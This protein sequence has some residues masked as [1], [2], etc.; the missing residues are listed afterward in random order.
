MT[1]TPDPS[2]PDIKIIVSD[3]ENISAVHMH[4]SSTVTGMT[5]PGAIHGPAGKTDLS[6]SLK[7][8]YDAC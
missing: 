7:P 6:S 8:N 2:T 5:S 3:D 4:I 1:L